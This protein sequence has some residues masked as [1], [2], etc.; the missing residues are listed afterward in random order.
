[1]KNFCYWGYS[2]RYWWSSVY[3][4]NVHIFTT[5]F[6][7]WPVIYSSSMIADP[8]LSYTCTIIVFVSADTRLRATAH[9]LANNSQSLFGFSSWQWCSLPKSSKDLYNHTSSSFTAISLL[10]LITYVRAI[11]LYKF[12]VISW[13]LYFY[14]LLTACNYRRSQM[15]QNSDLTPILLHEHRAHLW[16][17][18]KSLKDVG[19]W[20]AS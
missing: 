14:G 11:T 6:Q 5:M 10:P 16:M 8:G 2:I 7:V 17:T 9:L 1:M 13:L 3:I 4:P 18:S 20:G 19:Q 12:S 15:Y